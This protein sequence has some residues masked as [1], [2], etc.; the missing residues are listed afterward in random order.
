MSNE[1]SSS[2]PANDLMS[3]DEVRA[4]R[5]TP[6]EIVVANH[7]FH[8]LELAA[9]HL[10]AEPPQMVQ[11]QLVIDAVG[12]LLGATGDRLGEHSELLRDGLAQI[13]LAYVRF[14]S[15]PESA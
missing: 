15:T 3:D 8:L 12:G 7:V 4:L 1:P 11:A 6:P 2:D 13:R 14:S 10:S 5:A 9:L